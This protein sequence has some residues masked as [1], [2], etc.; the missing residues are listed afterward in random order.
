VFNRAIGSAFRGAIFMPDMLAIAQGLNAVKAATEIVKTIAGLRDSAKLLENTVEL[1]RKI[2]DVQIAL[3]AALSEQTALVQTIN[4]LKEEIVRMKAWEAEKQ[5]Y[6]LKDLGFGAFACVIK[7][8]MQG[9]E[10]VHSICANCYQ[11]GQKT[12]LQNTGRLAEPH[13]GGFVWECPSCKGTLN[14]T[15]WPSDA[16]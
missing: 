1:N 3:N 4:D 6:E 14:V 11:R 7:P 8:E 9:A 13:G 2:A 5:R 16:H 12:H 10:P 15:N